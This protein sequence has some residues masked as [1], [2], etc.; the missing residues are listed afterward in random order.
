MQELG[1]TDQ[2]E[3]EIMPLDET[4]KQKL[5][6][7]MNLL[8]DPKTAAVQVLV[9]GFPNEKGDIQLRKD[10]RGNLQLSPGWMAHLIELLDHDEQA[11]VIA[12]I[13]AK[14]ILTGISYVDRKTGNLIVLHVEVDD[15][16]SIRVIP[17]HPK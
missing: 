5:G 14:S 8:F 6:G 3:D 7:A 2:D 10:A 4:V 12:S 16:G 17:Q 13:M 1:L 9:V 11:A 15:A